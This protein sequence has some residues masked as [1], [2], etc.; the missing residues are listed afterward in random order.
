MRLRALGYRA[1][2]IGERFM[3]AADPGA[4]LAQL[5]AGRQARHKVTRTQRTRMK[6]EH[7][8][9]PLC[10]CDLVLNVRWRTMLVKICGITRLEDAEA[11]VAAGAG[12]IGFVFWPESP[13]FID[14]YRARA[15][16][17][18]LPP[19]VTAVGVFVNQP[20]EYVNGVASLVRLGA[21]QLHGDE[22]PAYAAEDLDAG[23]QGGAGRCGDAGR[24]AAW[25]A[26]TTLL[27]DA[28]DP[29]RR[30]GTGRTVDWA[31]AAA[32]AARR[33]M[34]LAGGLTPD[35]VG[36][37]GRAACGRSAS[38][39]RR[40]WNRRPASRIISACGRCSRHCMAS[41]TSRRDPDAAATSASSAGG[42]CPRRSSSRSRSSSARTSRRATIPTF[43]AEAR[44]AARAL[45]RPADAGLRGA[46]AVGS[47]RRRA[48]LPEARGSDAHRRAQ[49]QQRARPGAARGPHGQAPH[50]RRDRRRA[51]RRR[52]ARPPARCSASSATSTWAPRTWS[53]RR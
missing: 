28:H 1:F 10:P 48:D 31:A 16:G 17:R 13:R 44:S 32:L 34:L 51:A 20:V 49:D 41:V 27:L 6:A 9:L 24:I 8:R 35:N 22:T 47:G 53:G 26:D 46:A 36:G 18:A 39:C 5:L 21:V 29:V 45:R 2:L 37:R 38:T 11:A 52:D 30:G 14:P 25:P 19:F 3:T 23:D 40:A 12:A 15:I 33:R 43:T 50:R 42:T 7:E 4:A